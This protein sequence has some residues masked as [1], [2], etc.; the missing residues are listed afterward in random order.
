M[1]HTTTVIAQRTM[2]SERYGQHVVTQ[3]VCTLTSANDTSQ[4]ANVTTSERQRAQM[5]GIA[6]E[7]ATVIETERVCAIVQSCHAATKNTVWKN[8]HEEQLEHHGRELE[9]PHQ[10]KKRHHP[11]GLET[12]HQ[13][14]ENY[15]TK[16]ECP[17]Q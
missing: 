15:R 3:M 14:L 16:L 7:E 9:H 13:G 17:C 8:I 10:K 2:L 1:E 11:Q 6:L 5:P 12:R 4:E